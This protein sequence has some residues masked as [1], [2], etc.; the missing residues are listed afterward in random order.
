MYSG[1]FGGEKQRKIKMN[2]G[3]GIDTED[4]PYDEWSFKKKQRKE[5]KSGSTDRVSPNGNI[6][7]IFLALIKWIVYSSDNP[8]L[9]ISDKRN[10]QIVGMNGS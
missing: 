10:R 8:F 5:E 2:K 1:T 4:V 7:Y 6:I 9:C 3:N